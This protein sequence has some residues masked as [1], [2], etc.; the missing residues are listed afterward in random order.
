MS[1]QSQKLNP[2]CAST[3]QNTHSNLSKR[4]KKKELSLNT[5]C[6][7]QTQSLFDL[8]Y[9]PWLADLIERGRGS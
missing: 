8:V 3:K 1:L 2:T 9:K 5:R 6:I 7:L 4:K